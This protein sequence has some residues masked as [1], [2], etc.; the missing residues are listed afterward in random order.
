MLLDDSEAYDMELENTGQWD[1][2]T[3][4]YMYALLDKPEYEILKLLAVEGY[5]FLDLTK[6]YNISMEACKKRVQRCRAR[7]KE[8]L[9]DYL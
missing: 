9:K 7:F 6:H 8:E 3:K 2:Y 4:I 5:T 1:D